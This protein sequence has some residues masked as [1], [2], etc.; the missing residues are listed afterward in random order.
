MSDFFRNKVVVIT[1]GTD[2]IG[3]AL[4]DA[5]I[6]LGAKVAT[7]GRNYDKL[8]NLQRD[9]S[10]VMLHAMV[11]DV[12]NEHECERFIESTVREFGGIDILINNAGISMRALVKDLQVEVI[13]KV[14]D[15]NFFGSVYCTKFALPHITERQGSIVGV[16]S[17]AGYRGLPGRSGY[18]ASK[19]ALQ[20]WLESLRTELLD[21]NVHVMWVCPGFTT[22]NIRHAALDKEGHPQ[23]DSPM[24]E[25]KMMPASEV[26]SKILDAIEKRKRTLVMTF[27]GKRTVIMNKFF[28]GLADKMV[29][30]FFFKDGKLNK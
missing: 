12:S 24:D 14:M 20:G 28:P 11:C 23:G 26:A 19:F 7:C 22:S 10:N 29:H 30:K 21:S 4:I 9:Y 5:L 6:P 17:I 1:G 16:S 13:R 15:V 2:G 8:Y 27:T 25:G 18:S 3:R